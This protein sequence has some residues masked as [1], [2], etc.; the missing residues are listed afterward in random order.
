MTFL[1]RKHGWAV[2]EFGTIWR[3][4]N[5][6]IHW[7]QMRTAPTPAWLY[8]VHFID[9]QHGWTVG[10]FETVMR[11]E[12]GGESWV[13]E[14]MPTLRRPFGLSLN[15][16]AVRFANPRQGWI[17]GQHGNILHSADGGKSWQ[18]EK[19]SID[20]E[21]VDQSVWPAAARAVLRHVEAGAGWNQRL[22]AQC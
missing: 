22:V 20:E 4:K 1:D 16:R 10:R 8:D 19:L 17:V 18:H 6:G 11:T 21:L 7:E 15:F 5:G 14:P 13:H 9:G 12:D 2:G 3:T